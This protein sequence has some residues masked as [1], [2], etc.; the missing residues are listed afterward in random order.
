MDKYLN[1]ISIISECAGK[2]YVSPKKL[3]DSADI[4]AMN[5]LYDKSKSGL[6]LFKSIVD[7]LA[8]ENNLFAI[9]HDSVLDGTR[10]R[11][12]KYYWAELRTEQHF[13]IP[14]S[15]SLFAEVGENGEPRWRVSVEV[16]ERN[17]SYN[18]IEK[19]NKLI[20]LPEQDGCIYAL[21][22]KAAGEMEFVK[23]KVN[24]EKIFSQG[25]Y[26]KV[27]ICVIGQYTQLEKSKNIK[28]FLDE[29][30]KRLMKY[31]LYT[32]K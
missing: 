29:A 24:A 20:E 1:V 7:E 9:Y 6:A 22:R 14:E 21:S 18:Q 19:H 4:S 8:K 32:V 28:A 23:E 17:A 3:N 12:R 30:I 10:R 31:Y 27:Q 16:D 13:A 2:D 11:I 25:Q 5:D 26:N 15:I